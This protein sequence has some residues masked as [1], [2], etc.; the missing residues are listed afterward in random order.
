MDRFLFS[1]SHRLIGLILAVGLSVAMR[2]SAGFSQEA[3]LEEIVVGFEIPRLVKKD[4]FVQYDGTTVFVP[5]IEV[6]G[7]L[8]LQVQADLANERISGQLADKSEKFVVDLTRFRVKALGVERDLLRSHYFYDGRDFYLKIDLYAE[9]FGLHMKFD[10]SELKVR[11]PLSEDFP[12]FQKLER[13]K[14][15]TKLTKKKEALRDVRVLPRSREHI[16]GGALDWRI[17][18]NPV[19][20]GAQHYAMEMG[21]MLLGGD[22]E[23]SGG[24]NTRNGFETDQLNYLWHYYLDD[25]KYVSQVDLG[26]FYTVG[27]LGRALTGVR[28]TNRPQVR[29]K[30][31]QTVQLTGQPGTGWEVELYIGGRLTDFQ[32]TDASGRYDFNLDVFYGASDVQLKLYG[33][34][35]EMETRERHFRIPFNLIPKGEVEYAAALG[36]GTGQGTGR[37]FAQAGAYYGLTRRLSSGV[38]VDVPVTP[39]ENETPLYSLETTLQL[40]T[41]LTLGGSFSPNN[42]LAF[43]ANYVWPSVI[44]IGAN[45]SKFCESVFT[46]PVHQTYSWRLSLSS[47]L[48][49]AGR[50]LGLRFNISQSEYLTFNPANPTRNSLNL[51]YGLNTSVRPVHLNYIGQCKISTPG[52]QRETELFSKIMGSIRFH[53]KFRPQF[54]VNYDHSLARL[55]RYSLML[56]RRLWRSAQVTLSYERNPLAG[57]NSFLVTLHFFTDF[58]DFSSR[59][60]LA[61]DRLS[62]TQLQRGSV[63]FDHGNKRFL[64]DR[65]AAVGYGS[66]VVRPFRDDNYNGLKDPTEG[67]VPGLKAKISGVGGR[68]RGG[69]RTYYYDRMRPYDEYLVQIDQYSL[70]DPT[71]R[72]SNENYKVTLNPS[73]VTTI[74]VPIVTASEISG[75]V[76]RTVAGGSAGVGGIRVM[77]LNI[78]KDV[79]TE[80]T[81]FGD[82]EYYYLGLLPGSYRAYLDLDQISRAGYRS[83]PESLEFDIKPGVGGELIENISFLMVPAEASGD[84]R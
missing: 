59:S 54:L 64:F 84:N 32:T 50:Y 10:F 27:A 78:S 57:L 70:D 76:R 11:L 13:R 81:T 22:L 41:N 63:R 46:N 5:L 26:K 77:L 1:T 3:V 65:R 56:T 9:L 80:V 71:L 33:P 28:A 49:I 42:R 31:F 18:T 51:T 61:G 43:D 4:I 44:T 83:E 23:V 25:N 17:S 58:L 6:F 40:A 69:D 52:Q 39:I 37:G 36:Q 7:L 15:R 24:G 66:A 30:Y 2:P 79:L 72:P 67:R 45:A 60:Q 62:M 75:S 47:P 20:G 16:A 68:P 53:Q 14:A 35:G 34:N 74:E 55:T 73:V 48:R 19:G 82:G 21:G 8:D 12:A 38:N 29:R